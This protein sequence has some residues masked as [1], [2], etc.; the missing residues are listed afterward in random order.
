MDFQLVQACGVY[1]AS[2][3][4]PKIEKFHARQCSGL[5]RH[6]PADEPANTAATWTGSN[7]LW[8]SVV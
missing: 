2:N 8:P 6:V 4:A 5:Q 3:S 7:Q 1:G